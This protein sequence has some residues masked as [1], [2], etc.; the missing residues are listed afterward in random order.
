MVLLGEQHDAPEHQ[1]LARLSVEALAAA[2]RLSALVLEMADEGGGRCKNK[3]RV[4]TTKDSANTAKLPAHNTRAHKGGVIGTKAK[5]KATTCTTHTVC[6]RR[7]GGKGP[8]SHGHT[9]AAAT[10]A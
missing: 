9:H 1:A 3:W 2:Q 5:T 4:S 8:L 7:L 10:K 6:L